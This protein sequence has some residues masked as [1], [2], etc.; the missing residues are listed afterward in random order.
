MKKIIILLF[1]GLILDSCTYTTY[2][3]IFSPSTVV[4]DQPNFR[5]LKTIEGSSSAVTASG[6]WDKKRVNGLYNKAKSNMYLNH[7]LSPNQVITNVTE[8]ILRV[9]DSKGFGS[10][11]VKVVITADVYEFFN[12]SFLQTNNKQNLQDLGIDNSKI[13]DNTNPELNIDNSKIL[14]KK[15]PIVNKSNIN[16]TRLKIGYKEIDKYTNLKKGYTILFKNNERFYKGNLMYKL[17]SSAGKKKYS[18]ANINVF[19]EKENKWVISDK[20]NETITETAIL[21][22]KL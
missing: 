2:N 3:G 7:K 11:S 20:E 16:I 22:Y 9:K 13:S 8:D 12:G 4:F 1:A 17:N 19:N 10:R 14:D 21:G 5:Y 18:I 15:S 6:G